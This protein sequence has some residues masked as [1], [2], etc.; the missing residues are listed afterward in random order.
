MIR[1]IL[2]CTLFLAFFT[3]SMAQDQNQALQEKLAAVKQ[4]M[5]ENQA[6]LR[7]YTWV[8]TT[9]MSI[10]GEV[11]Q[12]N[13]NK[14]MYGADGMVQKTP[15]GAP[16]EPK[17]QARGLKG[18][19]VAQKTGELKDY[20][21][22]FGSLVS[23]YVPPDPQAMQAAFQAGK[24]TITPQA[25]IV[26]ADYVK[27]GD[28]VTLS[29]NPANGKLKQFYV[30]TYLDGPDDAVRIEVN[31]SGLADGTNYVDQVILNSSQ[32]QLQIKTTNFD[33]EKVGP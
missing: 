32:E 22:R 12:L 14:C 18:K 1:R 20:M 28:K 5:A 24:A 25:S 26:F 23:R 15:I 3:S 8:E 2:F 17:Q 9:E 27:P 6:R 16:P 31:F 11:K 33:Y 29:Q 4:S 21:E 7:N 19:I 10:K 30:S 13:Q